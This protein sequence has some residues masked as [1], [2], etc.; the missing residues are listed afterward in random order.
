MN[1]MAK[2]QSSPDL[3]WTV[4]LFISAVS[5]AVDTSCRSNFTVNRRL[6]NLLDYKPSP[7][8]KPHR[9]LKSSDVVVVGDGPS[10]NLWF[11]LYTP[12]AATTK[13]LPIIV[14]FHGGG[15]AF[16]SAS[17][18]LYDDF[19]QRLAREL[20]AVVVSVNYRLSP[21]HRYPCQYDDGFDVLK[22]IDGSGSSSS[23]LFEGANLGQCFLAG[24]SAGGN[25]AHHVAIRA[26]G[27]EFR[28]V[29]VVGMLA[30]QPFFGG[31]ER[32]ESETRLKNMPLVN[33]ERTD[34]MWKA[35][36][37]E[38]SDRDH[39]V[40]NVFGPNAV[41]ISGVDF[42]ATVVFVGGLDQL[43]DWQ[44]RYYEGLKKRGKQAELVVFP[45]AIHTFYAY[46]ELDD[47]SVFIHKVRD[48]V[49]AHATETQ[50]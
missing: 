35:F 40:A 49:Q 41:D 50:H 2:I 46:P 37:P 43:Q 48:F 14:F 10:R 47:S 30:I 22:F 11:R 1:K 38:G 32:T 9:N 3:P 6:W 36:L 39:P 23:C 18:K 44:K 27:H 42:P 28:Q 20:P 21:E 5:F 8:T 16:M 25:I 31:E 45:N 7:L 26:S 12:T 19:C 15:F 34:W 29:K 33:I 24:D 17:S 4:S 13:K